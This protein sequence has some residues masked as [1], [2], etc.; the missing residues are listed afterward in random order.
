MFRKLL[1]KYREV[2]GFTKTELA[3]RLGIS[4]QYLGGIENGSEIAPT[5]EM[6]QRIADALS[7]NSKEREELILSAVEERIDKK[8][9]EVIKNSSDVSSTKNGIQKVPII[10]WVSA[11]RFKDASDPFPV[12]H[13]DEYV[14]ST[15]RGQN[16]FALRVSNDC[17][18]PEFMEGDTIVVNP[19]SNI[20]NNDFII[21]RD[22]KQNEATFKQYKKY[23]DKIILHPLNPKYQDIELDH[24]E[25]YIIVGK[26]VEKVKKY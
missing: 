4:L 5:Q 16:L 6:C 24:D 7:L 21:V 1:T 9:L 23:G 20:N 13:A 22:N 26:V 12:G 17:M 2:R 3:K 10:S 14:H 8:D 11:N 15:V 18:S 19:S 25:R